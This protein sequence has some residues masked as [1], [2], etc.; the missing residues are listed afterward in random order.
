MKDKQADLDRL[1]N[2]A[3]GG[4]Q[5]VS[6]DAMNDMIKVCAVRGIDLSGANSKSS[7]Q[8]FLNLKTLFISVGL[9]V[10]ATV[11]VNKYNWVDNTPE[12]LQEAFDDALKLNATSYQSY[13]NQAL[14]LNKEVFAIDTRIEDWANTYNTLLK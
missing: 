12:M 10:L 7:F 5:I 4:K 6:L 1:F 14:K 13:R 9:I 11:V 2:K 3:R 8:K